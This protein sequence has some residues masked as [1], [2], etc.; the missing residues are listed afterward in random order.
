MVNLPSSVE[1]LVRADRELTKNQHDQDIVALLYLADRYLREKLRQ[2][3]DP[4][5]F[6]SQLLAS[7]MEFFVY[8]E[9]PNA[10]TKSLYGMETDYGALRERLQRVH[11]YAFGKPY[12]SARMT[13]ASP[14]TK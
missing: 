8:L 5:A 10:I 6:I 2:R 11:N 14:A 4:E 9:K 7:E 1:F 13:T 3:D 12:H